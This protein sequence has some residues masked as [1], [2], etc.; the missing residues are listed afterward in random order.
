MNS[1]NDSLLSRLYLK[2]TAFQSLMRKRIFNVL[3]IATPYDAF[4]M[5][6]DG[7]VEELV[8]FEYVALN[9][10]SPPRF[11]KAPTMRKPTPSSPTRSLISS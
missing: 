8:Y 7:R 10:S 11:V 3:L 6:E 2:D 9:L 5:E 1:V 4:M